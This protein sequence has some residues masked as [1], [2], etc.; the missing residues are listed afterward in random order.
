MIKNLIKLVVLP[1]VGGV[2]VTSFTY[3]F[4][5]L[6]DIVYRNIKKK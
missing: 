3:V 5:K 4:I 2:I 6:S 1:F